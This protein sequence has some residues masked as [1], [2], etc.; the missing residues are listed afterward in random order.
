[1]SGTVHSPSVLGDIRPADRSRRTK[2]RQAATV[3]SRGAA[4][5]TT[6]ADDRDS[7]PVTQGGNRRSRVQDQPRSPAV[8][9]L[10]SSHAARQQSCR[11]PAVM[12]LASSHAARQQSCRSPA[13]MP[14][15]S[16]HAARQQ[17]CRSPAVMPLASSHAARQQSCR[18]PR[19]SHTAQGGTRTP[20]GLSSQ[21]IL[22]PSRLPFRHPGRAPI[23]WGP[24]HHFAAYAA[25]T[26]QP[27][28]ELVAV[29]S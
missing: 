9:P 4:C 7:A 24:R 27:T 28:R 22:N 6:A 23:V 16:S 11:S 12:P 2:Y 29:A 21:R 10:A 3:P 20:T 15:A 18:S 19:P 5:P 13:V 25:V 17:S 26:A 1:M 14:L 8:M